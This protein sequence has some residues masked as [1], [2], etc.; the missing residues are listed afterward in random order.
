MSV[1]FLPNA[2]FLEAHRE[3]RREA[4]ALFG[5]GFDGTVSFRPG[6]RESVNH[7]RPASI[8]IEDYCPILDRTLIDDYLA[9]VGDLDLPMG[10]VAAAH[11][12]VKQGADAILLEGARPLMIGGEHSLTRPALESVMT[13]WPTLAVVQ[14]DAHADLREDYLGQPLSHASVMR[15]AAERVGSDSLFQLCIRSGT[16]DEW[17][18]IREHGTLREASVEGARALARELA[19]RPVYLT[20]DL[21]FLDPSIFPGTGTPE[22]GGLDFRAGETLVRELGLGLN[23]VAADVMELAPTLDPSGVSSVVAAKIVRT[24]VLADAAHRG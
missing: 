10:D 5:A 1:R 13:L 16:R 21:D 24:L 3:M 18:F 4:F 7:L 6:A 22:P 2:L 14:L 15:R 8:G 23:L 9:D 11:A 20:I 12:I 17:S 19:G